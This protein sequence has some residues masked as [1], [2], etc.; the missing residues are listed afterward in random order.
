[1]YALQPT[2]TDDRLQGTFR[3]ATTFDLRLAVRDNARVVLRDLIAV[4]TSGT[5]DQPQRLAGWATGDWNQD[6]R[7]DSGFD[8]SALGRVRVHR[9]TTN[10]HP[11]ARLR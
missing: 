10:R 4:F 2:L 7:F 6:T 1:M 8:G 3:D 11:A 9:S 5:Y